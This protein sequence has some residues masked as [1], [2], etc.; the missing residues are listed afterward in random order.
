MAC[1]TATSVR[2]LSRSGRSSGW[3][4]RRC[5]C[6]DLDSLS[7]S[8]A[9]T[10]AIARSRVS[11]ADRRLR[12]S[13]TRRTSRWPKRRCPDGVRSP[14]GKPCRASQVRSTSGVTPAAAASFP[15]LSPAS[16]VG[17]TADLEG[18]GI[19]QQ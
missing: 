8:A 13:R 6:S 17:G 10:R 1:E 12:T 9:S 19:L 5:A 14:A 4:L 15:M 11:P 18:A 16:D 7:S 3:A 2:A